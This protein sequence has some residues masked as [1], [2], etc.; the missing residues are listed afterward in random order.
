MGF[1]WR[2]SYHQAYQRVALLLLLCSAKLMAAEYED[3]AH[4][5]GKV[6]FEEALEKVHCFLKYS[7]EIENYYALTDQGLFLFPSLEAKKRGEHEYHLNFGSE[8][9]PQLPPKK[10]GLK[11]MKIALDPGH[12]GGE[13]AGLEKR[14]IEITHLGKK[15]QF[16]EGT[17][18]L[19][20]ALLLKRKLEER[21]AEVMITR[22]KRGS[23]AIQESFFDWLKGNPQHWRGESSLST[24]FRNSY[25]RLDLRE[26]ANMIN[27]FAPDFTLVIHYNAMG[28]DAAEVAQHNFNLVFIPGSFCENELD[29]KESR[30]EFLRLLCSDE[31]S[32]SLSLARELSCSFSHHLKLPL[33]DGVMASSMQVE[34]GIYCRNLCLTRLIRGP[35]CYGETLI[36][37]HPD[38][39][40]ML[41]K[42]DLIVDGISCP[43]RVAQVAD[44][45]FEGILHYLGERR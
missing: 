4:F 12:F 5:Q 7:P 13:W 16:D 2:A 32:Q 1:K 30:I 37:N 18:T 6:S 43:Q 23:G 20:T 17:L 44:A 31:L 24:L 15:Y 41:S 39:L 35:I 40:E 11:E 26:R 45:Y 21:G 33:Y 38:E 34:T 19:S 10:K 22:C 14:I 8:K 29:S 42:Q 27:A 3:F 36:Q 28:S 25:N 9:P